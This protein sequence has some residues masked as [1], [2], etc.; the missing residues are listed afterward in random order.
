MNSKELAKMMQ[1]HTVGRQ[2]ASKHWFKRGKGKLKLNK[3][4]YCVFIEQVAS[5]E[6]RYRYIYSFHFW[7]CC[8]FFMRDAMP[9]WL[10]TCNEF[11][12]FS[13]LQQV[14]KVN[15]TKFK[16]E[17]QS[18]IHKRNENIHTKQLRTSTTTSSGHVINKQHVNIN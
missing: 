3:Q 18:L 13:N 14:A 6:I 15:P 7:G 5:C 9:H 16:L 12:P 1:G 4:L 17:F 2:R 11:I 8:S 10:C